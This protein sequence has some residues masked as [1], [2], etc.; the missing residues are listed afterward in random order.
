MGVKSPQVE[1]NAALKP[2]F[3][4]ISN[5][6]LIH[7]DL[8]I[9]TKSIEEHLE[10]IR[11]VM[12]AIKSKNLTLNLN[13]CVFGSKGNKF[14][15]ILFSSEEVKPDTE[16]IKALEDLQPPKNMA[17]LKSFIC[18][19]PSNSDFIPYFSKLIAPL[20][21]LLNSKE[22]FDWTTFHQNVFHKLFREF[23]KKTL[24]TYFDINKQTFI[25]T[26]AQKKV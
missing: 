13:K 15:G 6:C 26:D 10:A 1:L 22:S 4:H 18:M 25:F 24:L 12:E 14:W 5:V 8:I 2:I 17:E 21:I 23:R 16:K 3:S 11:E 7:N 19:M 20:R 9:A